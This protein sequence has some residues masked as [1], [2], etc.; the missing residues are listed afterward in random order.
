MNIPSNVQLVEEYLLKLG[1]E[2]DFISK[3][4]SKISIGEKQRIIISICLSLDK[5]IIL[6]D[7]PTSSLD[8]GSIKLLT[9]T[10]KSLNGK[11]II[12]ASHNQTW[13][14]STDKIISL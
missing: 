12:S 9:D 7:E 3:D 5:E 4:F 2:K 11:T 10:I 6:I 14:D 13:L 8:V 1:L